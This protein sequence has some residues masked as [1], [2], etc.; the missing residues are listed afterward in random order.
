MV[1]ILSVLI[2]VACIVL[3]ITNPG[4]EAHK[5]AVYDKVPG[6]VGVPGF[7]G[8]VAG[9]V[10][11]NLDVVPLKYNN[12]FLFST[13]TFREEIVSVGLLQHVHATDW[14]DSEEKTKLLEVSCRQ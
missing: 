6:E 14:S 4:E 7:L 13:V 1:R 5:K 11:E 10:L 2:V 8:E 3:A 9:N 12:Y